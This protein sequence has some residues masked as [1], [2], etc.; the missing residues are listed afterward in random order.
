[1]PGPSD[2]K[3]P[4][5]KFS[6]TS[7]SR[8]HAGEQQ[9]GIRLDAQFNDHAESIMSLGRMVVPLIRDDGA[10]A[11]GIVGSDQLAPEIVDGIVDE[12]ARAVRPYVR[13]AQVAAT[14]A[15]VSEGEAVEAAYRARSAAATVERDV[16]YIRG[17]ADGSL[18]RVIAAAANAERVRLEVEDRARVVAEKGRLA[19]EATASAEDY[20]LVCQAWAEYLPD[21]IPPNL[22][23][24]MGVTGDHWSSRF[25]AN[26]ASQTVQEIEADIVEVDRIV[27]DFDKRYLGA[28]ASDPTVDLR[29]RP[30]QAG[31]LYFNVNTRFMLVYDGSSWIELSGASATIHEGDLPP[32]DPRAGYMWLR[33]TDM[34]LFVWYVVRPGDPGVWVSVSGSVGP[35]GDAGPQGP[36]GLQGPAGVRGPQGDPGTTANLIGDFKNR[37]PSELPP[38]GL[39]PKDWDGPGDPPVDYQMQT[40]EALLYAPD[41]SAKPNANEIYVFLPGRG[42]E[43]ENWVNVGK[44][45]GPEGPVGPQGVQGPVG[46]QG[47]QGEKGDAGP[48]GPQ[49]DVGPQGDQGDRGLKGDKGDVGSPGPKGDPGDVGPAG[50]PGPVGPQGDPGIQGVPGPKG[51]KGDPGQDA[52]R[53]WADISGKP[54]LVNSVNALSGD[55]TITAALLGA[56]TTAQL[57]V[58]DAEASDARSKAIAA[59]AKAADAKATADA[60]AAAIAN[61]QRTADDAKVR[62]DTA[63]DA[64]NA[65]NANAAGRVSRSGD[66]MTGPLSATL[67]SDAAGD[68][69]GVQ[70]RDV[71]GGYVFQRSDNGLHVAVPG[72]SVVLRSGTFSVG[73]NVTVFNRPGNGDVNI[74]TD[75]VVLRKAGDGDLGTRVLTDC[76]LATILCVGIEDFVVTGVGLK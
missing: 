72:G 48:A 30:L 62:A 23:A 6:F 46:P 9:P 35:K 69:R 52:P 67:L 47:L 37:V 51:D 31:A 27:S 13:E 59:D 26:Q 40:G 70:Q 64:A 11:N 25:W 74:V 28:A 66:V 1:M 10:L 58:V 32:S 34:N 50:P 41:D 54:P 63:I 5:R 15:A 17:E 55:V 76:G 44:I 16:E 20:A 36:Q 19:E 49:G 21:K 29:G 61:A 14:R 60:A 12:A 43:V 65:A 22:L 38:D 24:V 73:D 71:A 39:I 18:A 56:A 75:G 53:T 33:T 42:L 4:E 2:F 7:W 8:D 45:R 57:D 68:V 3:R